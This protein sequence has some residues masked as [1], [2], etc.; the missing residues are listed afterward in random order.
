M[1]ST[2]HVME[3]AT[4][5]VPAANVNEYLHALPEKV[6][7]VLGKLRKTIKAAAPKAEEL[8]S[9]QVPPSNTMVFS[10]VLPRLKI[11]AVY[12]QRVIQ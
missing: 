8:I 5:A 2:N 3:K 10:C 9:Y 7:A 11:T 12:I 1:N 6:C 4:K